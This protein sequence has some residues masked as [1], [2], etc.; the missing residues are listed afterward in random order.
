LSDT[1]GATYG[2]TRLPPLIFHTQ[3]WGRALP[4]ALTTLPTLDSGS[5]DEE[6]PDDDVLPGEPFLCV[7]DFDILIRAEYLRAFDEVKR[8]YDESR[9][10]INLR[11]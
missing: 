6:D 5:D 10:F 8:I 3:F 4:E 1:T 2:K 11:C 7:I 9:A